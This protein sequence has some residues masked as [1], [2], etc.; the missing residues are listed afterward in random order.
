MKKIEDIYNDIY[1]NI[2]L[3]EIIGSRVELIKRGREW[4]G[5]CPNPEHNDHGVGSFSVNDSKHIAKCFACGYGFASGVSF[6]SEFDKV[7]KREAAYR[8]ALMAGIITEEE[9][10]K[11]TNSKYEPKAKISLGENIKTSLG[12]LASVENRNLVYS[13][14][15]EGKKLE[16]E[17]SRLTKEHLEYLKNRGITDEEIEKYKYFSMPNRVAMRKI[18]SKLALFGN[19]DE[20]LQYVPGFYRDK[21]KQYFTFLKCSG[22][23]IPIRNEKGQ[24][25]AIQVRRDV[26]KEGESRYFWWSSGFASDSFGASPGSPVDVLKPSSIRFPALFITEGHFKGAVLTETFKSPAISVQGVGNWKPIKEQI[27]LFKNDVKYIYVCYDA[28]MCHNT[29][30]MKQAITMAGN[31]KKSYP[32]K[33][34]LFVVWDEDLGKGIDDCIMAGNVKKV[35]R[36]PFDKFAGIYCSYKSKADKVSTLRDKEAIDVYRKEL[37]KKLFLESN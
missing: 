4:V 23:G 29:A 32:D 35:K 21:E 5:I 8:I 9:Y 26:V 37:F 36:I 17:S 12:E 24:I 34:V 6:V 27:E 19:V 20:L 28:D 2:P 22:I 16:G 33:E 7:T 11:V 18:K 14:F 15:A 1:N 13:V 3:H 25:V 10:T 30:V 31:L